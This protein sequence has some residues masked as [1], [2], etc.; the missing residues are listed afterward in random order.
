MIW[1]EDRILLQALDIFFL[2]F[3]SLMTAFNALGWIWRRTR[4]LH[5][6]ALF[7]T[8][9]SWVALGY[10]YGWGYCF[11]TEWHWQVRR[12]MDNPIDSPS[13]T[14]FLIQELTGLRLPIAWVDNLTLGVVLFAL[15]M[16]ILLTLRDR[17]KKK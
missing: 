12:A 14:D 4:P 13:Y 9:F 15:V 8:A 2:S 7:L 1:P 16:N 17:R 10:F 6:L 3:H 11:L 5:Q